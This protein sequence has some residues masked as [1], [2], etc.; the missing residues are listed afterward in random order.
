MNRDNAPWRP[1]AAARLAWD[2]AGNPRSEQFSDIYYSST[3]GMAESRHVFL[4]GN[5]LPGRWRHHAAPCFTIGETGFG[6]GLNFLVAWQAWRASPGPRPDLHYIAVERYPLQ[7]EQLRRALAS[8]PEL[9]ALAEELACAYPPLI[10]GQHRLCLDGGRVRLDLWFE[11]A[12]DALQDL[13]SHG[14]PCVD[15][16]FLDGFA[17]ARNPAMWSAELCDAIGRLTRTDGTFATFTAA[18][19]VRRDLQ[20]AGFSVT[21]TPGFGRKRE[22]LVGRRDSRIAPDVALRDT[23]WDLPEEPGH[24][25]ARAIVVGAGLA[26]CT[27]AHALAQ[28]GIEVT[29]LER[30][31]VAGGGSGNEQGILYTRLSRKHS[32]LTDFALQS[33][34]HAVRYYQAMFDQGLLVRGEDGDLCGNLQLEPDEQELAGLEPLLAQV[35]DLAS[36]QAR[37]A[38]GTRCGQEVPSGG[39]WLPGS[40]WLHPPA[41]CR[42]LLRHP[43]IEVQENCGDITLKRDGPLWRAS[44][45]DRLIASADCA[46]LAA[47]PRCPDLPGLSWLA[48]QRIR[49]QTTLLPAAAVPGKLLTTLCSDGYIAPARGGNHCI[50]ASFVLEFEDLEPSEQEHRD[51]LERIGRMLPAWREA[52]AAVDVSALRGRVG[53]RCASPD[54]LPLAGPVPDVTEFVERYAPLRRNARRPIDRR[55]AYLPG[56][57][58]STAHGSRGLTSTPL[59]AELLASQ[60]CGEAPPLSRELARA[61]APARFIIRDL[62][63]NRI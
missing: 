42:A 12:V 60:V 28:R 25:P 8:W 30:N 20:D 48:L 32:A 53:V 31:Q 22:R 29:V 9:S 43:G 27:V 44:A 3:D 17:P 56:L 46:V 19:Q 50:G 57:F 45:G 13:A 1:L 6:S 11:D 47:G 36:V 21:K 52:L 26:G 10:P 16:W 15:A 63:R 55:G 41:V 51:N 37:A 35:D 62:V 39:F 5:S 23:P 40:G 18:G 2:D 54:Y 49:G 24:R 61:L 58:L 33:Y 59:L 4:S 38:A 34:S 14:R 7:R